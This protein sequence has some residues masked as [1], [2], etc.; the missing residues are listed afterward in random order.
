VSERRGT[1]YNGRPALVVEV[2]WGDITQAEGDV[3][4]AGHYIGVLPQNAEW[5]LDK[6]I[7]SREGQKPGRLLIS[8]LTK[9]GALRGD[10]GEVVFFPWTRN[11][12]VA[13]AGM[14]GLGTFGEEQLRAMA[15]SVATTIGLLPERT[16]LTS[17]L[18]G[19]GQG[20]L[21][22]EQCVQGFLDGIVD[23]LARD[24][25]LTLDRVRIVEMQLDKAIE[26]QN[27]AKAVCAEHAARETAVLRLAPR[28]KKG[29]GGKVPVDFGCSMLLATLARGSARP[30]SAVLRG[31]L[32]AVLAE[33]PELPRLRDDIRD[34]LQKIIRSTM[35]RRRGSTAGR[36]RD[37]AMSFRLSQPEDTKQAR[38]IPTRVAFWRDGDDNIRASAISDTTT[39]TE[40][41]ITRR[42]GLVDR[43][44]TRL[45]NPPAAEALEIGGTLMRALVPADLRPVIGKLG[46][47]V[48]EVDGA[49][50]RVQWEFLAVDGEPLGVRR[51][52]ARQL[53][54]QYS[55]R[56]FELA[57]LLELKAL[58]IGDPGDPRIGHNL[59]AAREEALA[60]SQLL[61]ERGIATTLL[62][63]APDP[64]T[65]GGTRGH[66]PA[67]FSV[68]VDHL[69][70][71]EFD[72]VHYCGHALFDE[73]ASKRSGWLFTDGRVL[74]ADELEG[75][76]RPP[77]LVFA[78][79]CLTARL[80]QEAASEV[81]ARGDANLVKGLADEFFRRGVADYI[82]TAWEVPSKPAVRFA[83]TFYSELLGHGR[84]SRALNFGAALQMARRDLFRR[85]QYGSTWGAYQHYGDPTRFLYPDQQGRGGRR[86]RAGSTPSP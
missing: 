44:V 80:G 66:E 43:A 79:A 37:I 81:R 17:V 47:L 26:I 54:T 20:N 29:V 4:L 49:L 34:K 42:F 46:P 35:R 72:I 84:R 73:Q 77:R 31:A 13:V 25:K 48:I 12:I 70:K 78:N 76:D 56:P 38:P 28:I 83:T 68:V 30:S 82:G 45:Q 32:N 6:A 65:Q 24:P 11:R 22:V 40:R 5:Q 60:V 18:I 64:V 59:P 50:S 27:S 51:P 67:E 74:S 1:P 57:Q 55:V 23:A 86:R 33:L 21:T 71:G 41:E 14:G 58:V 3:H 85:K 36:L 10:L 19:S 53:R 2:V 75:M 69:L 16:T 63:G 39:V 52:V 61:R 15:R 7:S 9:R 8:E 62:L